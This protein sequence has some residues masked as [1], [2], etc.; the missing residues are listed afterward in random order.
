VHAQSHMWIKVWGQAY[1]LVPLHAPL[2][3]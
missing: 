2:R 1:R 3:K